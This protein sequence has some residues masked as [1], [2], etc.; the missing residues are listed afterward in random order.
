MNTSEIQTAELELALA[1]TTE[2]KTEWLQKWAPDLLREIQADDDEREQTISDLEDANTHLEGQIERA[3]EWCESL[4]EELEE[5]DLIRA[6]LKD[7]AE[8]LERCLN[9]A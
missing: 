3:K 8:G 2:R 1:R 4:L 6:K 9:D 7:A 5:P